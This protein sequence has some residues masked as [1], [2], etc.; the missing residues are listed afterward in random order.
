MLGYW[1]KGNPVSVDNEAVKA[2]F[3]RGDKESIIAIA[4]FGPHDQ[5]CS[6]AI[7]AHKFGCTG[8]ECSFL[9]PE[10][11]GYQDEQ[12][13]A[14]LSHMTIPGGKGYLVVVKTSR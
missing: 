6:L 13:P 10:I 2:T 8:K 9:I 1:D 14:S 3:Y 11:A 7:D 12:R 5:V 4:N